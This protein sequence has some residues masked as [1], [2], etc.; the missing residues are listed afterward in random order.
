MK[1][2]ERQALIVALSVQWPCSTP[3]CLVWFG[4]VMEVQMFNYRVIKKQWVCLFPR[5][6]SPELDLV[7][8]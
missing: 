5:P 4:L 1:F 7:G 6:K 3:A 2:S 8:C